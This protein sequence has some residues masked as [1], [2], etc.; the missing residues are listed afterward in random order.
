MAWNR[1]RAT[2]PLAALPESLDRT[3]TTIIQA[4]AA[5]VHELGRILMQQRPSECVALFEEAI[6][7][8][9][10]VRDKTGEA[11]SSFNLG[12]FY[13][14]SDE[15]ELAEHYFKLILELCDEHDRLGQGKGHYS[16]GNVARKRFFRAREVNTSMPGALLYLKIALQQYHKALNL[17][18]LNAVEDL[19]VVHFNLGI[20]YDQLRDYDTAV[21]HFY[22]A[23]RKYEQAGDFFEAAR[24][25]LLIGYALLD[26]DRLEDALE[27]ARSAQ[28]NFETL[29]D[30]DQDRIESARTLIVAIEQT[31]KARRG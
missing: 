16:L 22:D 7:L 24:S 12:R 6:S 19:A 4:L 25:R 27:Y 2:A 20:I 26:A 17:L 21:K 14:E 1:Q 31:L 8:Y 5:S 13:L 11:T 3:Q 15:L 10:W 29:R 9:R 23:I 30:P 28:R 18:P